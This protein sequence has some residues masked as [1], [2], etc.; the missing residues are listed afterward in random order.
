M[1]KLLCT[2]AVTALVTLF[3]SAADVGTI[4][5]DYPGDTEA[6][7]QMLY[8]LGLFKGT[9]NGF[10]LE[11]PMT[12]AEAAAMLTRFLGAEQTARAGEWRHPFTDVPKWADK[13]VGWLYENGMTK[14]VSETRYG[15]EENTSC[16]Q[17]GTFL[18]RASRNGEEPFWIVDSE[19]IAV[20][21]AVGFVRGDAV[22]LAART[23]TTTERVQELYLNSDAHITVAQRLIDEGIFT[24]EMLKTAA[25][26]VLPR[27]YDCVPT[28]QDDKS[29]ERLSCVIAGVTVM[30]NEHSDVKPLNYDQG[31]ANSIYG[32]AP[33]AQGKNMLHTIDAE[34][35]ATKEIARLD[36]IEDLFVLGKSGLTDYIKGSHNGKQ[37]LLIV[38]EDKQVHVLET[39]PALIEDGVFSYYLDENALVFEAAEMLCII[40]GSEMQTLALAPN[41]KLF[42]I[43]NNL[44]ITQRVTNEQTTVTAWTLKG[45]VINQYT[46]QNDDPLQDERQKFENVVWF[47]APHLENQSENYLWG[48]AGLYQMENDELK[49]ITSRPVYDYAF[50]PADGSYVL[51]THDAG[52]RVEYTEYAVQV[53]TGDTLVRL[54]G[55][56]TETAL[57]PELPDG[58]LLLG[59]VLSTTNGRVEFTTLK[60]AEPHFMSRFTCV[61]ENGR[62]RVTDA[63]AGITMIYGENAVEEEQRRLDALGVGIE[64]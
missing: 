39:P 26:R 62:I 58:S 60:A 40:Q 53:Q 48:S 35:L 33:N 4:R 51:I 45:K 27:L 19:E 32:L 18:A 12:R 15:A 37:Y 24:E 13:Y 54:N 20:C 21:D 64:A 25:W 46:L 6:Q 5:N 1:K 23:L 31:F 2:L 56:G 57:L 47:H 55:D 30:R 43:N 29:E 9:E 50:D 22:A 34:T 14:G 63:D 3:A 59:E 8:E 36:G 10:E 16:E 61:L 41:E 11:K 42:V 49:Q 44:I 28:R 38:T 52:K 17:F 7:A